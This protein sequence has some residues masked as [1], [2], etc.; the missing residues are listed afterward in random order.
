MNYKSQGRTFVDSKGLTL[1]YTGSSF[2]FNANCEGD[3]IINLEL[4]NLNAETAERGIYFTVY[5]DGEEQDRMCAYGDGVK[6]LTI[7]KNLVKG[8]HS[9]A[10]YRQTEI[11]HGTVYI[12]SVTLKGE[13]TEAPEDKDTLIQVIGAS[14]VAGYGNLGDSTTD[15]AVAGYPIYED[16]TQ[17]FGFLLA[18]KLGADV[19]MICQQGIGVQY[20]W[21]EA[22][23]STVY[24]YLN[25]QHDKSTE[26][27]FETA[28]K[29]DVIVI[30]LGGNDISSLA[31]GGLGKDIAKDDAAYSAIQAGMENFLT[32]L[33]SY[34]PNAKIIWEIGVVA[35]AS[36]EGAEIIKNAIDSVGGESEGFY[37]CDMSEIVTTNTSGAKNHPSAAEH[38]QFADALY[39][40]INENN[41][42]TQ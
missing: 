20:G 32:T 30:S 13:I 28:R 24:N 19:D 10:I 8:E 21:R 42:L 1:E 7:A 41:L 33:R 16:G 14:S 5:V 11:E 9:F 26:F 38:S 3:V 12:K 15:T 37:V 39:N 18:Q 40:Y 36:N 23:M 34:Y 35:S 17:S 29:P 25:Y 4:A 27:D 6:S 2:E 22:N 31:S